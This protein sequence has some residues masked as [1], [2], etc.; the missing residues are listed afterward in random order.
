[1]SN[2][3]YSIAFLEPNPANKSDHGTFVPADFVEVIDEGNSTM[4]LLA[5]TCNLQRLV[6]RS[7]TALVSQ[8]CPVVSTD[9][10]CLQTASSTVMMT[11]NMQV[12]SSNILLSQLPTN[13]SNKTILSADNKGLLTHPIHTP[14]QEIDA[15]RGKSSVVSVDVDKPNGAQSMAFSILL[16]IMAIF[17]SSN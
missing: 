2:H 15:I 12:N 11:T 6:P 10:S 13:V 17:F 4:D 5:R 9:P 8:L 14:Q 1:M 3:R 7:S 16:M